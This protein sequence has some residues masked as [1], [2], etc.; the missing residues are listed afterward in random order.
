MR[1]LLI[2]FA[3][4]AMVLATAAPA[5]A[6]QP[7]TTGTTTLTP[8]SRGDVAKTLSGRLAQSDPDL[9]ARRDSALVNIM[10]KMDVQPVASY[11]GGVN[12][13]QPTSPGTTGKTLK[14]NGSA[15][16]AYQSY[17]AGKTAIIKRA[18]QRAVPAA[19]LGRN[20]LIAYGGFAARLPANQARQLLN[21]PGVAA[22]QYDNVA[23]PTANDS[24]IFVGATQVWPSLGGSITAGQGV[25]VGVID[26]GIWPEHPMFADLG[27]PYP[28]GTYGCEFGDGID[29]DF[30][31]DFT[32]TDKLIGAYAF[33]DT[34]LAN[35]GAEDGEF[36]NDADTECSARDSD[37][38]GTH[39][40]STAAGSPV[41][42]AVL[43]GVDRGPIS[44]IAPGA[45]VIMYRVCLAGGC[46]NSD[47]VD[48]VEQAITD[49]V[50]VINFSISGGANPYADAVELAFLDAFAAGIMVNASAGNSGPGAATTD[51]GG[52]WVN[53]VG[54]STLDRAFQSTLHLTAT[55]GA[56]P[57]TLD[58]T[59]VTVTAGIASPTPVKMASAAPYSDAICNHVAAASDFSGV[60]AICKRGTNARV[61]KG[62]NVLQGGAAGMILY[63]QSAG[64]TDLESDNHWL[65]AI[66]TNYQ[67][68]AIALFVAGHTG[69]MATWAPGTATAAQ[70]DV[71]ASFSSRGPLGD[72]IKPDVTAPGVQILAGMSPEHVGISTGPQGEYYQAI[73]GTSMSSPH[74][75]GVA[76]LLKAAHPSWT[77]AQIK[78]AMMTSSLQSV[79]KEDGVT[80]SDPFDRGAG[81]IRVNRAI[82][83]TVTFDVT[84]PD[85]YAAATDAFGR[86]D[87][88]LPSI[89]A[90][91]MPGTITTTR[92]VRNATNTSQTINFTTSAPANSSIIITPSSLTLAPWD[93]ATFTV[94]INGSKLAD[95]QYF[96]QI[97]LNPVKVGYINAVMPVAFYKEPGDVTLSNSCDAPTSFVAQTLTIAK[98]ETANCEVSVTNYSSDTAH[99]QV[100]VK[101][102]NTSRLIIRNWSAGNKK[103]N[104]FLWNGTLS[105]ALPPNVLGLVSPGDGFF[106]VSPY[107]A[108]DTDFTDE[109]YANYDLPSAVRFGDQEYTTLG[110]ISDGYLVLGGATSGDVNY[111]PQELPDPAAPNNV[112][113]PYWTDLNPADGGAFYAGIF[114]D[115]DPLAPSRCY[116]V[117]QWDKYPLWTPLGDS[118]DGVRSFQ[119]WMLSAACAD[120]FAVPGGD[121]IT[122]EYGSNIGPG[123]P[124]TV[125]VNGGLVVGAENSDGT[126][127]AALAD[128]T[129]P[130]LTGY[131]V[132]T[133]V[134][135]PGGTMT[136][137]YDAYGRRTGTFDVKALMT[138]DITQGTAVQIVKIHVVNL[139]I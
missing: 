136:I 123:A 60:I 127:A 125:G 88:N 115:T 8:S 133:G 45:S 129:V 111:I 53:T 83:P 65:P 13:L 17:L 21:V 47:T 11:T 92:T 78:S 120:Y 51:H 72:F 119:I 76:A 99:V 116:Y 62:Y 56:A 12:N 42:S 20:F 15:V 5:A 18:V 64:V 91:H 25:K 10:V 63:N 16:A 23:Q 24:P 54:A 124:G 95:G 97:T 44:G 79:V 6:R 132:A 43:L 139:A 114:G 80:P 106:D 50:D 70:G 61:D 108:G 49:D 32:C 105:P 71:M 59:G 113:A 28:G 34:Y 4:A 112:L 67:A 82:N 126:S 35:N 90:P 37:G 40:T 69:V 73:A 3:T 19:R 68:D 9:L 117:F 128:N 96:G 122:F 86:I 134:S 58:I 93:Q 1:R 36:C 52:P 31:A 48:A 94:T 41:A 98:G 57:L 101:A 85:Y 14:E 26:T 22:V 131:E 107:F 46:F 89:N 2:V 30:G 81:S 7:S 100:T 104:G 84:A 55:G 130:A 109:S 102:P 118:S 135:T 75:A 39:T 121:Y 137:T 103:A 110:I 87:L 33:T 74:A 77:P 66:H 27:I 138:S 38:H 29:P